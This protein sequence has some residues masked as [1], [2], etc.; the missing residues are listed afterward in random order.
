VGFAHAKFGRA[1]HIQTPGL[2]EG[3]KEAIQE[4][5]RLSLFIAGDVLPAPGSEFSEFVR[6]RHGAFVMEAACCVSKDF[7]PHGQPF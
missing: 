3:L 1:A 5:L 7:A 2:T 6:I 4:D